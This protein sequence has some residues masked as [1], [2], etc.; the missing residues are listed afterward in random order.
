MKDGP[1]KQILDMIQTRRKVKT[2]EI[3]REVKITTPAKAIMRL[4]EM[5]APIENLNPL[6]EEAIYC[7]MGD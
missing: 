3:L 2:S 1:Q 5:G 6:G 7:W 4:R